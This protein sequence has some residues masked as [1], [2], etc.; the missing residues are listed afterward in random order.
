MAWNILCFGYGR[1]VDYPPASEEQGGSAKRADPTQN[2]QDLIRTAYYKL[3]VFPNPAGE[4]ATFRWDLVHLDNP[5]Q[6][7][8]IDSFGR[9]LANQM[10]ATK[11]GHWL[12]DTRLIGEGMYFYELKTGNGETLNQGKIVIEK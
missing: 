1:C 5:A 2:P 12:W 8:I 6:L 7:R 11:E 3:N 10:V 4:Y 9:E